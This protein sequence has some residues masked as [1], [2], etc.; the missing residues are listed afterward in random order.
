VWIVPL[1]LIRDAIA[2]CEAQEIV[3][4]DGV[5][6]RLARLYPDPD[7][8]VQLA[9][10]RME[11]AGEEFYEYQP[12]GVHSLVKNP[13]WILGW[14]MRT[15]KT[16]VSLCA[17]PE[18][19]PIL[20]TVPANAKYQW[21]DEVHKYRPEYRVT[22]QKKRSDWRWPEPGECFIGTWAS[23]APAIKNSRGWVE[24]RIGCPPGLVGLFDE[25]HMAK[26]PGAAR[27]QASR[28][29]IRAIQDA[30]GYVWGL[31]GT[32][33]Q[34]H[35]MELWNLLGTMRVERRVFGNWDNFLRLYNAH[36]E[37]GTLTF[38][39][40]S[41]EIPKR[42][43][44]VMHRVT[45]AQAAPHIK[46]PE[47]QYIPI[48][49]TLPAKTRRLWDRLWP[50]WQEAME[51][52]RPCPPEFQH[53]R[54]ELADLKAESLN[55]VI[56]ELERQ[57][58]GPVLVFSAH[59]N[60]ILGLADRDRWEAVLGGIS[61]TKRHQ[62]RKRF[63]LGLLDGVAAT[64][65][66]AAVALTLSRAKSL[67]FVDLDWNPTMN[68]QAMARGLAVDQSD[69]PG[70]YILTARG[71]IDEHVQSSLVRKTRMIEATMGDTKPAPTRRRVK[72]RRLA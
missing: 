48:D 53:A 19:A 49:I 30:G 5:Y 16:P 56:T 8:A 12:H 7:E 60:P 35:P 31:T 38:G 33:V 50:S 1:S 10:A 26:N 32:P 45:F 28:S 2:F 51:N 70:V 55:G 68:A 29:T 67:L 39:R 21:E 52:S 15:G 42:L 66:A 71:T 46:R 20:A 17:V 6:G 13:T 11:A 18:G 58:G 54:K 64:I 72:R 37:F 69:A 57:G 27:T 40:P 24:P 3:V 4:G 59:R 23:Q 36:R 22:V 14:E 34:N 61:Q 63:Q 43:R 47:P 25:F 62:T 44:R 9:H 41:P 65:R